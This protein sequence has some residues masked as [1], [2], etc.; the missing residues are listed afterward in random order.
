M[1]QTISDRGI[2]PGTEVHARGLRWEVVSIDPLG[3]QVLYRLRG[4]EG[5]YRGSEIDVLAP[6]E[7]VRPII[8]EI[9]PERATP[10]ANWLVYHKAFLLEQA[11]GSDALLAIQPGRLKME[12]YQ[13]VPVMRAL[14]M[15][16]PRLILCDGVGLGKTIQAG[17]VITEL[18]A[19]RLAHRLLIVSPAGPL[20]D[21]W[22]SELSER[23]GL[24][25]EVIDRAKLEDVRRQ[26]ELGANPF[27][28]ISL[29]LASIDFLKQERVLD[30]LERTIYDIIVIDE[31]HHCMDLGAAEDREDSQRRRLAEVLSRRCDTLLLLT[32][33]PHD[34]HD[35]S[36][37]SL[38]ELLD[39]SLV[40]GRGMIRGDRYRPYVV[41]RLKTHIKDP[42]TGEPKFK[43]R[44]VHPCPVTVDESKHNKFTQMQ[45]ALLELIAPELRAAFRSRRYSDVL[46]FIS[47]LKRSVSTAEA[48]EK[49]LN[50]VA[51]RF[52]RL[53]SETVETQDS[54]RQRLRTLQQFT[55]KLERFGTLSHDEEEERQY[56]E[57][58]DIAQRLM[59]VHREIRSGSRTLKRLA[60]VV[61]ALNELVEFASAAKEQ[62]PKIEQLI[63][64]ILSLRQEV[65]YANIL[66]F[67]EYIDSQSAAVR[68]LKQAGVGDILTMSGEDSESDRKETKK[69][70]LSN[71]RLVLVSTDT[72]AEGLNLHERC[73]HLIHLELPFNPNRLEQRNGR[74]DRYGQVNSPVVRYMYLCGTF[75]ERIL[76]RLIAK[77]ERQR[78]RLTFVP[79][80]LGLT[81]SYEATSAPLLKSLMEEDERLFRDPEAGLDFNNPDTDETSNPAVQELLEEIDRSL[82]GFEQA[83]RAHT[84]LGEIGLNASPELSEQAEMAQEKGQRMGVVDL[85]G[86][87][88]DAV[89]LDGGVVNKSET[90]D[91]NLPHNW[92]Y[93]LEDLPGYDSQNRVLRLTT[94]VETLRDSKGRLVGFL[95]RAH[96]LVRYALDR[97][98]N[99]SFGRQDEQGQDRRASAVK[100]DVPNPQLLL[101]Y[102]GK[103]T[104]RTGREYEQV[105]A[106]HLDRNQILG[107]YP[108]AHEWQKLIDPSKAIRT[109]DVWKHFFS[110]WGND[111]KQRGQKIA[112]EAFTPLAQDFIAA[113]CADLEVEEKNHR[114]WILQRVE[115]VIGKE[116]SPPQLALFPEDQRVQTQAPLPTNGD[117]I[118]RLVSFA[119]NRSNPSSKRTEADTVLRIYRQRMEDLEGRLALSEPEVRPLGLLMILPEEA[120]VP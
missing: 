99:I 53:L 23:F 76:L 36:F 73:H 62:D 85:V 51:E 93:G 78:S 55:R 113:R 31:A 4:L 50:A 20:L 63:A 28:H 25:V 91:L 18:M 74:I 61:D 89:L 103:V 72:A 79:N 109:T 11:L 75:E 110:D 19:R 35:R 26:S 2:L 38:L 106:V 39:P 56:L 97:V 3:E 119:T 65:P 98:R 100:G 107:T 67:T 68:A 58:E 27:D 117:P 34:G 43:T 64:E 10:L 15:S 30:I 48:C 57:T 81:A 86:F 33:T 84:W 21:Q 90:M 14:H 71:D 7:E 70:F 94:N 12:P 41:R 120:N 52:E 49:T 9:Q 104:S 60:G 108:H 1:A 6:F 83:A 17:L 24:R 32:A 118:E 42:V 40:D 22:K 69:R 105:I 46:S 29:G 102:L 37:A 44:L 66:V 13:L 5:T 8:T 45:R 114:S 88:C 59:S 16:R 115:E 54:S 112:V 92:S 111:A 101:T 80:T 87:V 77:Y 82:K 95:G 96:P 47:L 116:T